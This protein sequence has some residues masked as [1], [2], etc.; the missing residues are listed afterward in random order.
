[1]A[2]RDEDRRDADREEQESGGLRPFWSGTITFGLVSVP[3]ELY[4]AYRSQ[5][6]SLRMVSKKGTP[7]ERR[8]ICPKHGR[9]LDR[10]E[11][12]R[13][14]E[15]EEGTYVV[16]TDEELERLAPERTRDIDLRLFVDIGQIDP[17]LFD[18]AWYLAPGGSTTKAYRLLAAIMEMTGRAGIATFV[19]RGKEYLIAIVA[20]N[21]IL[22]AETLR[23]E[24][25]VRSASDVGLPEPV[26]P[27]AALVKRMEK[28][29][30][31]LS[32]AALDE[33]EL[34]DESADRL[35]SLVREKERR[36]EDVVSAPEPEAEPAGGVIDLMEVLKRSLQGERTPARRAGSGRGEGRTGG[37]GGARGERSGE[38]A[39]RSKQELYERAK[40]L[41]IPGR[42]GMTKDQLIEAIRRSA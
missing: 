2:E 14:Y 7:L 5:R 11:I 40:Q 33:S 34:E 6:V 12:V 10:D 1:M 35:L 21:G 26:K 17:I 28:A 4:P 29:V 31:A 22:R 27:K 19:M 24:E 8:Y 23:F 3:V 32:A 39:S 13:G 16:L 41:D 36:G 25:E 30:A 38:L 20:E 15:I 9:E 42:S 37:A 18:R